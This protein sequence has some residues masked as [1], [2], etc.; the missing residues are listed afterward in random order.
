MK[1]MTLALFVLLTLVSA[2]GE[3]PATA[4]PEPVQTDL[5]EASPIPTEPSMPVIPSE[6]AP[7]PTEAAPNPKLPAASF[8][9]Q[10]YVNEQAGFALDYPAGWTVNEVVIGP[11]GTQVQFLSSPDLA[12]AATVPE[13]ATRINATIYR[14]DP[15]NDLAAYSAHRKTAWEA[16]GFQIL[17]EEQLTL[18]LGLSAVRFTVQTPEA[19][20][21]FLVAALD[22]QYLELS[23]EGDM[24]LV[25]E[26]VQRVRPISR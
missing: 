23:G 6:T 24:E 4:P 25:K 22:D 12:E 10:T 11:R 19:Q 21:L 9:A 20:V 5:P 15:K 17:A 16:S 7:A 26:I 18:E 8:E 1:R 13:G 2:C 3:A 14:W